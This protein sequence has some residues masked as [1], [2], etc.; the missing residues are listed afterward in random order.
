MKLKD[1]EKK[2]GTL[3]NPAKMPSY[4]WGIPIQYCVTGSKLA[5][6]EGTICNKCYAGKGCYVFPVVKAMYEK[7]YQAIELPE[8]VDYMAEL[9]TQKYKNKKEEDRYHRW[10]DSGDVQSYSHLMKIFEVCELTPHIKYWLATR[11]YKIVDQVKE[12]DVPKNLCLRVSTTK[13]DNPPPKFWK[14]TSG[15]HKDKK[16]VGRECPAYLTDKNNKVWDKES[17]HKLD[18]KEKKKHDFGQC[19]S[20]RACWSRKVKQVSYKEH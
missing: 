13:V 2:I 18:K 4:A 17:Y 11:E 10:F 20:C 6:Q 7:R 15:V 14:W 16:A 9:I 5:L 12:E 19:G 1:I 8:W 3:S